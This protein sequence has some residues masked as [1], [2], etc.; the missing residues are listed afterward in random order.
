M[1]IRKLISQTQKLLEKHNIPESYVKYVLNELFLEKDK[2]LY[3]A[4]DEELSSLDQKRFDEIIERLL[5][6]EPLAYVMGV[7]YFYGYAFDVNP[8]V[9][10]PRYETEEMVLKVL[11]ELDESFSDDC[12]LLD[13][14]TGSGAIACVLKA[15]KPDMK[16]YASDISAEALTQA[17]KNAD[18][19]GVEISFMQGDMAQPFVENKIKADVIVCNPPY[20]PQDEVI[21]NSVKDYEPHVA[22]FGGEDGLYF[23]R[24]VLKDAPSILNKKSLLAFEMGWNQRES[25]SALVREIFPNAD[26]ECFQDLSGKD[27]ILIVR[28]F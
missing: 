7:Q 15:E 28:N 21:E 8:T 4:M 2:N 12:T 14:G 1:I 18:K 25:L 22:L 13:I 9:L 6:D 16:V 5:K 20:I 26:I 17:Q 24:K 11:M 23:Y 10:I 27:R 19:L 3:D